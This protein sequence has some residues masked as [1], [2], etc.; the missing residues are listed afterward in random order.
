VQPSDVIIRGE[1]LD[2]EEKRKES[3]PAGRYWTL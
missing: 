1:G 2:E 3:S